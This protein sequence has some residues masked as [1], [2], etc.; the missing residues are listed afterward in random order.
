MNIYEYLK[1]EYN[2]DTDY[3]FSRDYIIN[4][5]KKEYDIKY[6][7]Y[8]IPI[9]NDIC[10]LYIDRNLYASN[11]SQYGDVKNI[12]WDGF[13]QP[14]DEYFSLLFANP[15]E[16][17]KPI[18]SMPN[19]ISEI[20]D[21]LGHS[22]SPEKIAFA[23]YLLDLSSKARQDLAAQIK[24]ALRRQ[25][26]LH[27]P[28]PMVAFGDIKYCMFV[29]PPDIVKYSIQEQLD[30][31]YAVASRNEKIPVMWVSLHYDSNNKL[32]FAQGK[33]CF[34]SDLEDNNIERM[35]KIGQEKAKN[36]LL[37]H[38]KKHGKIGRND[39][40]PCGSGKKYKFCCIDLL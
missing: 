32:I 31:T 38:I 24:T 21:Y 20:I 11:P 27:R 16:A 28:L 34:F 29:S 4:P 17:K 33:K 19:E 7:P 35:R 3:I 6:H 25:K 1:R 23:H 10:F 12:F 22:I 9:F 8:E 18:Q 39:Y 36:F 40:C 2:I 5:I 30:Y 37:Q 26:E 13:R 15:S 14:L